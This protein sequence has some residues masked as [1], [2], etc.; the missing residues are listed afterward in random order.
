MQRKTAHEPGRS[1]GENSHKW[2]F[3]VLGSVHGYFKDL[4]DVCGPILQYCI[5][6][7]KG[8]RED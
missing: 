8:M 1:D 4:K 2:T 6:G 7:Y 3:T 5:R